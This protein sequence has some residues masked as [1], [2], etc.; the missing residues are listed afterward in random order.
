MPNLF[1]RTVNSIK[2]L[3]LRQVS[4][5]DAQLYQFGTVLQPQSTAKVRA[6]VV[7][8]HNYTE[9]LQWLPVPRRREAQKLVKFQQQSRGAGH[10]YLLGQPLNGKTPVIWYQFKP[11]VLCYNAMLYLPETALLGMQCKPGEALTYQSPDHANN[12]YLT[13]SHAG[14]VSAI[15]GG[16][17]QTVSQFMLAQGVTLQQSSNIHATQYGQR[18]RES[19]FK[20]QR[21]PLTGL[22][23]KG[24]FK[25]NSAVQSVKQYL[26]PLVACIT[27]YLFMTNFWSQYQLQL[28][29]QQLQLANRDANKLLNQ[30]TDIDTMLSRYHQLRQVLPE[31]DNLLHLWQ[32][33]SPLYQQNVTIS[34]LQQKQNQVSVSIEAS[35]AIDALQLLVQQ[36][37]VTKASL[38][39]DVRRQGSK[40]VATFSF[41]LQQEAL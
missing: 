41:V 17:L 11:Q 7:S 18:L 12:I 26:W 27:L 25:R 39:G 9:Q 38:E 24:A 34:N 21:L 8:R 22:V 31:S 19:L 13:G 14:A 1:F 6:L 28:S 32:V 4:Y 5:L 36:P 20:L 35:S 40:D 29:Q 3:F 15:Q 23:N 37:G 2:S 30:R 16:L 33:L 10:F